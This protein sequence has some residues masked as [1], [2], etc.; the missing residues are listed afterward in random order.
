MIDVETSHGFVVWLRENQL[1]QVG[2]AG[3][4]TQ[5]PITTWLTEQTD[6]AVVVGETMIRC[7]GWSRPAPKWIADA[8]KKIDKY[9]TGQKLYGVTIL[10][11]LGLMTDPFPGVE[12][13]HGG[14][15]PGQAKFYM[16]NG[17]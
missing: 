16:E 2:M 1:K 4:E 17:E 5:C 12:A 14:K 3:N 15:V 6:K 10:T 11:L 8:V 9:P 7:G 13:W